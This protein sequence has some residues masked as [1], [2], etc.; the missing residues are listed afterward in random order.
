MEVLD[1]QGLKRFQNKDHLDTLGLREGCMTG[2]FPEPMPK[3]PAD[4]EVASLSV[5]TDQEQTQITGGE[6]IFK[7]EP[8]GLGCTGVRLSDDF[9]RWNNDLESATSLRYYH[10]HQASHL[11][12]YHYH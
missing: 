6:Y 11:K 2:K 4:L 1:P 12:P 3:I 9:H 10:Y 5:C 8:E 7:P